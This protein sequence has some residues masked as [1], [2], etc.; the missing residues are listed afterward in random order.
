M[1]HYEALRNKGVQS[2]K[3]DCLR[4][5]T[6]WGLLCLSLIVLL[7][8]CGSEKITTSSLSS[9]G[10]TSDSLSTSRPQQSPLPSPTFI[11]PLSIPS[12][13]ATPVPTQVPHISASSTSTPPPVS[14]CVTYSQETT[15]VPAKNGTLAAPY[16]PAP[17]SEEA[18]QLIQQLFQL[19]N[20][21]RAACELPP[22]AWNNILASGALLHSWNMAHCGFSHTCPDGSTPYQRIADEG[23]AGLSD[24]GESIGR[25]GPYPTAWDGV[26]SVQESMAHEPLGGW[27]RIHLFSTTLHRIGI[28]VY[29]DSGG[30][31]WFSEDMV[32]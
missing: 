2:R 7:M 23:F 10:I 4:K 14:N 27:H 5:K 31:I 20:H 1:L 28:G 15:L 18:Q 32:S 29:V 13:K 22:F 8:A 19:I 3:G 16:G 6:C 12:H 25:A 21:E 26:Y 9:N 17:V 30:W 24:C 11:P